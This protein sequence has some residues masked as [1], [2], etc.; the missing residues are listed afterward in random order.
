ML[1]IHEEK[2]TL[3]SAAVAE[4]RGRALDAMERRAD[5]ALWAT[6]STMLGAATLILAAE[7]LGLAS[8]PMEGFD[9]CAVKEALGI[10]DDHTV[11]CLVALGYAAEAKPF[12]GRFGLDE[13]CYQEHFGQPW[14]PEIN[15]R[16]GSIHQSMGGR[17]AH[18]KQSILNSRNTGDQQ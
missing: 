1:A 10:P 14:L 9:P 2:G 18:D 4:I 16:H 8:A 13:V 7:S 3:S 12:L 17:R 5:P 6:R 15:P 11:C